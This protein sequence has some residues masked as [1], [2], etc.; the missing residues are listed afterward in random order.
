V[1]ADTQYRKQRE[2]CQG[3]KTS[4]CAEWKE[5]DGSQKKQSNTESLILAQDERWRSA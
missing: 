1:K 3:K 4:I 5:L 2:K